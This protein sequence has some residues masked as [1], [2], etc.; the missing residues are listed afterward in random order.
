MGLVRIADTVQEFGGACEAA[1]TE[2]PAARRAKADA[3]LK[4]TSWDRTWSK[5]AIL[6]KA[7][8]DGEQVPARSLAAPSASLSLGA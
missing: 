6:L 3:Y 4:N 5:T 2:R 1:L 7:V 8:L